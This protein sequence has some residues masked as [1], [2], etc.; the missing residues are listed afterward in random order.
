MNTSP[1]KN[2]FSTSVLKSTLS[3]SL[4]AGAILAASQ[5]G[6]Q[7]PETTDVSVEQAAPQVSVT[8]PAPQVDVQQR[9]AEV[10]VQTDEP[11]VVIEPGEPKVEVDQPEPDIQVQQAQPE[12][13]VNAAEPEVEIMEE[14]AKIEI[15][16]AEPNIDLVRQNADG[17]NKLDP[18]QQEAKTALMTAPVQ[19]FEGRTVVSNID[20]ELGEVTEVVKRKSDGALGFIVSVGGLLGIGDTEYFVPASETQLDGERVHWSVAASEDAVKERESID[21]DDYEAVDTN[22]RTLDDAYD[23]GLV[24]Q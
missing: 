22:Y 11:R 14:Q 9:K 15:I 2:Y 5:A 24:A 8:Q 19:D 21:R 10:D 12:V 4:L 1:I 23:A 18:A 13:I 16:K 17:Q 3:T 7:T 20:E 6:A